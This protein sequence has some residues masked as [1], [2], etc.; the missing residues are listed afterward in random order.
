MNIHVD[1]NLEFEFYFILFFIKSKSGYIAD[2]I[3]H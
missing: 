2:I 1:M 3:L